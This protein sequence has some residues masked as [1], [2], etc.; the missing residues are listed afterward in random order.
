MGSVYPIRRPAGMLAVAVAGA[1]SAPTRQHTEGIGKELQPRHHRS[2]LQKGKRRGRTF[3]RAVAS[4]A[5]PGSLL[6]P[7]RR[8]RCR[9][10]LCG[11]GTGPFFRWTPAHKEGQHRQRFSADSFC[12]LFFSEVSG[13]PLPVLPGPPSRP[14]ACA[15]GQCRC[16][17]GRASQD[18]GVAP[19]Q[20]S[21]TT[22]ALAGW[23]PAQLPF[24]TQ[25]GRTAK[26]SGAASRPGNEVFAL[27]GR[28]GTGQCPVAV[29]GT[30]L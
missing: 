26:R 24:W 13:D 6:G 28:T 29:T 21:M 14:V 22:L 20:H 12:V 3:R 1:A 5:G 16:C 11:G 30:A 15:G 2:R 19:R 27:L 23:R 4:A 10:R 25:A 8:V 18:G 7:R 9:L 17:G